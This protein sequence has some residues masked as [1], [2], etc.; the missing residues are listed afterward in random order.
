MTKEELLEKIK[1]EGYTV[2]LTVAN[3]CL[4]CSATDTSYYLNQIEIIDEFTFIENNV[5]KTLKTVKPSEYNLK[6]YFIN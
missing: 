4:Y 3:D 5:T 2:N 6:G 1:S